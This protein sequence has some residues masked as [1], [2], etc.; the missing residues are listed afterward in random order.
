M[1][2]I[3][4][5]E[6]E[7]ILRFFD[8][9]PGL[10]SRWQEDREWWKE[11][12]PGPYNDMAVVAHY[13]VESLRKGDT[14][15]FNGVFAFIE[16]N[17]EGAPK[18]IKG[19]LVVGL[20]ETVQTIASHYLPDAAFYPWLGPTSK[21]AWFDVEALWEGKSSLMDVVRAHNQKPPSD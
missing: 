2:D 4:R 12:E 6:K 11:E 19:L 15:W 21:K 17:V 10:L 9:C 13:L 5:C 3:V 18:P 8:L 14:E 20:L 7:L 1:E 16:R